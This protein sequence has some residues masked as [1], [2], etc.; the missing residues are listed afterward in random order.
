MNK[1]V[2][3]LV[4]HRQLTSH[5]LDC[6]WRIDWYSFRDT[7]ELDIDIEIPDDHPML[8]DPIIQNKK[9][10]DKSDI[11]S[12][13]ECPEFS[14][15]KEVFV[16][17]GGIMTRVGPQEVKFEITGVNTLEEAF[18]KWNECFLPAAKEKF[19]EVEQYIKKRQGKNIETAS[20]AMLQELDKQL[21]SQDGTG[22]IIP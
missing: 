3:M 2:K 8:K 12:D 10:L 16:G 18:K 19:E 6:G 22:I 14:D 1:Q 7:I 15:V 20:P 11:P 17:M 9:A 13:I 4:P 5:H 21:K